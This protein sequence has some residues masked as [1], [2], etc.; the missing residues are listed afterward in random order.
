MRHIKLTEPGF[1]T[2]TG[3]FFGL[4]FVNGVSVEP[5]LHFTA[6]RIGS[7]IS[8]RI[9]L[10]TKENMYASMQTRTTYHS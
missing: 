7:I 1:E 5:V 10:S 3:Q 9:C 6:N 8:A 4:E 2:G